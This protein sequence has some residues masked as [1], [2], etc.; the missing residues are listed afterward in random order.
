MK[1]ISVLFFILNLLVPKPIQLVF[2]R[3]RFFVCFTFIFISLNKVSRNASI[4]NWLPYLKKKC[5]TL[6]KERF[7]FERMR[8]AAPFYRRFKIENKWVDDF[9][10]VV[11]IF[12]EI[13]SFISFPPPFSPYI[14]PVLIW[15][16]IKLFLH[17]QRQKCFRNVF[18]IWQL[19]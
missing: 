18:F 5:L 19:K 16:L 11:K 14:N 3:P 12:N 17:A 7:N 9:L 15:L 10:V 6:K 8:C 2:I 13:I 1:N 4:K